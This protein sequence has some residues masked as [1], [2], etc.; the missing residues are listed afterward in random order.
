MNRSLILCLAT[1]G[2]LVGVDASA[3]VKKANFKTESN[4]PVY[5]TGTPLVY[6]AAGV[7]VGDAAELTAA[8]LTSNEDGWGGGQVDVNLA[9]NGS[10]TLVSNDQWDF[11][12]FN[13][14]ISNLKMATNESVCGVNFLGGELTQNGVQPTMTFT[15][16]SVQ[17]AYT[18]ADVVAGG[19]FNF[20]G[21]GAQANFQ[22]VLCSPA[23]ELKRAPQAGVNR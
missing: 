9:K 5:R 4:L 11:Q 18:A 2:A 13:V 17:I 7:A 19:E 20:A 14:T 3:G 10:L 23:M 21:G 6:S 16:N 12:T 1:L 22:V 8:N 15:D